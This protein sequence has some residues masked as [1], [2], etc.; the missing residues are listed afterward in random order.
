[1]T[2]REISCADGYFIDAAGTVYS[3]WSTTGSIVNRKN[4]MKPSRCRGYEHVILKTDNGLFA[5]KVHRLVAEAFL[6]NPDNKPQVNH[7]NGIKHDNRV[8]NLEWC[9]ASENILHGRRVLKRGM[10]KLDENSVGAIRGMLA[11]GCR[12][13]IIAKKFSVSSQTIT[14]IKKGRSWAKI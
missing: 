1:M 4:P 7:K 9:T 3:S 6:P 8:G 12:Q 5:K 2:L 14:D 11:S 10:E 13:T